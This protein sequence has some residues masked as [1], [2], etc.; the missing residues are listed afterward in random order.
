M[1]KVTISE[2]IARLVNRGLSIDDAV[3]T[4]KLL[5]GDAVQTERRSRVQSLPQNDVTDVLKGNYAPVFPG[6][7]PEPQAPVSRKRR[8][9]WSRVAYTLTSRAAEHLRKGGT[10]SPKVQAAID[11]LSE[12]LMVTLRA[13]VKAGKPITARQL[14]TTASQKPKTVESSLYNLRQLGLVQS[15]ELK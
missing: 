6:D 1:C 13:V 9:R 15:N 14:E 5:T 11:G 10:K 4:A 8:R 7:G 12:S 2:T 3:E